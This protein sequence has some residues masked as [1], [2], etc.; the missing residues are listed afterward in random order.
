MRHR[1]CNNPFPRYGGTECDQSDMFQTQSCG[2][3]KCPVKVLK[4][5]LMEENLIS[6]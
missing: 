5:K 3:M 6:F 1:Q 2:N 4:G